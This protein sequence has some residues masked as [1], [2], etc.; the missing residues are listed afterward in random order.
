MRVLDEAGEQHQELVPP[1]VSS[2][3]PVFTVLQNAIGTSKTSDAAERKVERR[4]EGVVEK[5]EVERSMAINAH[6]W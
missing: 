1:L 3:E 5:G 4:V 6:G 2:P